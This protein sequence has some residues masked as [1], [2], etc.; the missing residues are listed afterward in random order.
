MTLSP[1]KC[2]ALWGADEGVVDFRH[3]QAIAGIRAEIRAEDG[4]PDPEAGND[5]AG[6]RFWN[7]ALPVSRCYRGAGPPRKET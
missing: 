4:R 1:R 2:L 7:L 5:A 6:T 3:H